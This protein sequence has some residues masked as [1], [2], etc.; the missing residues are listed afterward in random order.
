MVFVCGQSR[1]LVQHH[2]DKS[3]VEEIKSIHEKIY[4]SE[5]EE[6]ICSLVKFHNDLTE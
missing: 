5:N 6:K 4:K 2:L 3:N 1:V